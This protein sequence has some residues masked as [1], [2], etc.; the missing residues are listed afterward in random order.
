M[1]DCEIRCSGGRGGG[2][3]Q[4]RGSVSRGGGRGRERAWSVVDG[5]VGNVG[6][7]GRSCSGRSLGLSFRRLGVVIDGFG[8]GVLGG[9]DG[10]I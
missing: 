9:D 1:V 6:W 4:E 3:G 8:D 2:G 10:E 7:C 5:E